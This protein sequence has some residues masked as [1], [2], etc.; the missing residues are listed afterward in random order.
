MK[1]ELVRS[2]GFGG[3]MSFPS[4]RQI[5]RRFTAWLMRRIDPLS[6][7]LLIDSTKRIRFDKEDVQKIFGIPCHGK[8]VADCH[9][10]HKNV[11]ATV[12][13]LYQGTEAK[14]NRSIKAAQEVLERQYEAKMTE[15]EKDALRWHLSYI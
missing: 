9:I 12:M 4:L 8:S 6:Q 10:P 11:V 15:V 13:Q 5:N 1:K 7:T 3:I 2:I 14:D